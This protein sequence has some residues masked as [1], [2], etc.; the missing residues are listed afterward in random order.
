[1]LAPWS[2]LVPSSRIFL[3]P[4]MLN[5]LYFGERQILAPSRFLFP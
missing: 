5:V 3:L 1:M 2:L 4:G